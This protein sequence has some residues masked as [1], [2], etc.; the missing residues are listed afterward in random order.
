MN[1]IKEKVRENSNAPNSMVNTVNS[2]I[3]CTLT[4]LKNYTFLKLLLKFGI[5][6]EKWKRMKNGSFT[7]EAMR[8]GIF[9]LH[10]WKLGTEPVGGV[11]M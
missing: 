10:S 11:I 6:K 5:C 9:P 3:F 4:K 2:Y 8:E 1:S 7:S